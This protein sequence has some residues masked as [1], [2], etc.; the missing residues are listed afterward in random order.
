[1][2]I[3]VEP[4]IYMEGVG[5]YRHSDTI[6]VTKDGYELL[7]TAPLTL[8]EV[9]IKKSNTLAKIKGNIIQKSLKI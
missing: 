7:T 8:N 2:V 5:G 6:I 4:G 3:T 1:M 9:I